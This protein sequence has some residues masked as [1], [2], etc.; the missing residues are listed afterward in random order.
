MSQVTQTNA[1]LGVRTK[2][3]VF[4]RLRNIL[5]DVLVVDVARITTDTDLEED[6]GTESIDFVDLSFRVEEEFGISFRVDELR[7][8]DNPRKY[9]VD[10][11][12]DYIVNSFTSKS[13]LVVG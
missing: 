7:S 6:L 1:D 2:E 3:N 13:R 10:L 9:T 4:A 5:A 11:L 8:S 12:A